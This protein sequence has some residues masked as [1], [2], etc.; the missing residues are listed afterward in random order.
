MND[1]IAEVDGK[2]VEGDIANVFG[3]ADV[4]RVLAAMDAGGL[5]LV[6]GFSLAVVGPSKDL[7]LTVTKYLTNGELRA[8]AEELEANPP[9]KKEAP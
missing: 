9:T 7:I 4:L 1:D 2:W 6:T 3:N 8:L 5:K